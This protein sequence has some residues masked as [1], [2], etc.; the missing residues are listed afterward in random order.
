MQVVQHGLM[1]LMR[2]NCVFSK[3]LADMS[4]LKCPHFGSS[5]YP[6]VKPFID[7]SFDP[8]LRHDKLTRSESRSLNVISKLSKSKSLSRRDVLGFDQDLI[9]TVN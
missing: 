2:L 7:T 4:N 1:Y 3:M 8:N 9:L 5:E 6:K